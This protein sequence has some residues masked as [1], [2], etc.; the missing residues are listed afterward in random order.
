MLAG[1]KAGVEV[2]PYRQT[3]VL[4]GGMASGEGGAPKL[5]V[6]FNQAVQRP[7]V[8]GFFLLPSRHWAGDKVSAGYQFP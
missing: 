7:A 3:A 1:G 2:C 8:A 6:A 4:L 5:L